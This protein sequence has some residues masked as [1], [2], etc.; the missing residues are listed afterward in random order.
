MVNKH[1]FYLIWTY[2]HDWN[3]SLLRLLLF[4]DYKM[5]CKRVSPNVTP[6][7][8]II[9]QIHRIVSKLSVNHF[10]AIFKANIHKNTKKNN[11]GRLYGYTNSINRFPRKTTDNLRKRFKIKI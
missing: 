6:E 11:W 1:I 7:I 4:L 2:V 10:L 3:L 8:K 5:K 9:H